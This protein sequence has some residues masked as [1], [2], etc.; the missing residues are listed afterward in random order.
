MLDIVF[1][2]S[3]LLIFYSHIGYPLLL[4]FLCKLRPKPT[5]K[6]EYSPNVDVMIVVYNEESVIKAKLENILGLKYPSDKLNIFVA[7][8]GSTDNTNLYVREYES[9]G[10]QLIACPE[11]RGK[12]AALAEAVPHLKG[13][14]I[15][16][17][18]ARQ[19]FHPDSLIELVQNF[20]DETVGAVSG[21]LILNKE[22]GEVASEGC[23]FYWRY[24]KWIRKL[25][26]RLGSVVG[27]TGAI[28]AVRRELLT[29]PP[30]EMI[31]DDVYI[32][33]RIAEK[34]YRVIFEPNAKAY[35]KA[36]EDFSHEFRRKAR[37]LAGNYQ[38]FSQLPFLRN[39]FRSQI[40]WQFWSHKFLRLLTPFALIAV[41]IITAISDTI[42]LQT[43]FYLQILFY[44]L[45]I[46]GIVL[47]YL[48]QNS[49]ITVIPSTFIVMYSAAVVGLYRFI[50]RAQKVTWDK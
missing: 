24:E 15:L 32:P 20:S 6:G 23:G 21:E 17:A 28:Y 33:L 9:H 18:D 7:S 46:A 4:K 44:S 5:T 43:L 37:T 11:R 14:I 19:V 38:L 16:F 31:L 1:W 30:E 40:A 36:S 34:G 42:F 35:D 50:T 47:S 29:I 22:P 3:I 26:S 25:E 45:G 8:D 13:D 10:V 2:T 48:H 12:I 41:F 39:P 27:A 49:R